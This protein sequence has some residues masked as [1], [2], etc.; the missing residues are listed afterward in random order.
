MSNKKRFTEMHE[1]SFNRNKIYFNSL[2]LINEK[3]AFELE[4]SDTYEGY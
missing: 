4:K 1:P 2:P 3:C